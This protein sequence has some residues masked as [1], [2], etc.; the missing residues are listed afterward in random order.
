MDSDD[1]VE[2]MAD[3]A[4]VFRIGYGCLLR[5]AKTKLEATDQ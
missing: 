4:V 2:Y 5:H 3:T 1:G